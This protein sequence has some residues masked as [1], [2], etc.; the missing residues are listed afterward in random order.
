M[1]SMTADDTAAEARTTGRTSDTDEAAKKGAEGIQD[2]EQHYAKEQR[3]NRPDGPDEP[4]DQ[5]AGA[6]SDRAEA[7]DGAGIR[8][9]EG[10]EGAA[11]AAKAGAA[12][13]A[14]GRETDAAEG[15][16]DAG[17]D[18][19]RDDADADT[20]D[21]GA[22]DA[23]AATAAG[24]GTEFPPTKDAAAKASSGVAQ[25]AGAVIAAGL[26]LVSLTGSW[27]GTVA[28]S[29]ES[30]IGQLQTSQGVGVAKQIQ[31]IYGD[32]WHAT[33]LVGG[34]FALLAMIVGVVVLAIPAFGEPGE[35]QAAWIK[36]VSWAGVVLGLIGLLL[37]VLKY[38]DAIL[39]LP[40]VH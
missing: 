18:A 29:R 16:G 5:Q 3:M 13:R 32:Q 37:A 10:P 33:A 38:S 23:Y 20:G 24:Y 34:A 12:A 30:L 39:G 17:T 27:L 40:S 11:D 1:A 35:P 21:T 25:G 8:A 28:A 4:K 26:S 15:D 7:A 9:G 14:E 19:G 2:D 31:E 36:S 22:T 6:P